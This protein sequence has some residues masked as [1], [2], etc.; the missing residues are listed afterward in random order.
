MENLTALASIVQAICAFASLLVVVM[1]FRNQAKLY[2]LQI[3]E[4]E[5]RRAAEDLEKRVR[6][7][8]FFNQGQ[9]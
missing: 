7:D 3:K 4:I 2:E 6:L 5:D 8:R 1:L 9:V